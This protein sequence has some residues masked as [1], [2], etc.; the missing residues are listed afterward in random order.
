ML[1]SMNVAELCGLLWKRLNLTGKAVFSGGEYPRRATGTPLDAHNISRLFKKISGEPELPVTWHIFRH[2]AA[3]FCEALGMPLSD[4]EELLGHSK[5]Q[6]TQHYAHSDVQRRLA[7]QEQLADRIIPER[8]RRMRELMK[9]N[10]EGP[11]Q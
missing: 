10:I 1:T 6:M 4:R 2:S 7:Y 8:D 3:T 9:A 11:K 5:A